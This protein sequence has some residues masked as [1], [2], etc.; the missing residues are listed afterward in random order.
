MKKA[1]TLAEVLITLGI[2]GI[3]ASMTLPTLVNNTRNK[4]IESSFKKNYSNLQQVLEMYQAKNGERLKGNEIGNTELKKILMEYY[5]TTRDCGYYSKGCIP[6]Y[7][8]SD[9][10]NEKNGKSYKTF[11][12]KPIKKLDLFDDGQFIL[13][14]GSL[15]LLENTFIHNRTYITIDVNGYLKNPN[16]WGHDI[17][18]FQLDNNGILRPMGAKGTYYTNED[19]YCSLTSTNQYN[20]IACT[21]KALTDNDYFKNLPR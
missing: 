19:E 8:N 16:K 7:G 6:Y 17:F 1:F 3:V 4:Q 18:T 14:D 20:G 12:N 15:V 11:N 2:I 13:M 21:Y 5:K 10:D 9:I